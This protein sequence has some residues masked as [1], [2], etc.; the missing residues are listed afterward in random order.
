MRIDCALLCDAVTV[1]DDLLHILGGGI[2]RLQRPSWP[3]PLG[4]SLAVRVMVHPTE[5]KE[6]HTLRCVL[7]DQDGQEIVRAEAEFSMVATGPMQP[8]EEFNVPI[9]IPL[10]HLLI[11]RA[12]AYSFELLVDGVHQ[13]SVPFVAVEVPQAELPLTEEGE[14]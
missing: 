6:T 4:V 7:V 2:T 1:R 10:A 12:T 5:R 11:P 9:P 3:G 13:A 8:G 14:S